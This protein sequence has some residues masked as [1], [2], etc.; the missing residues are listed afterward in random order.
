MWFPY[1]LKIFPWQRSNHLLKSEMEYYDMCVHANVSFLRAIQID[2]LSEIGTISSIDGNLNGNSA[3]SPSADDFEVDRND[4][5]FSEHSESEAADRSE[6]S[7]SE[8]SD[9]TQNIYRSNYEYAV[10]F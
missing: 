2:S 5:L 10:I 1:R 8:Q 4:E 7:I 6:I 9:T 3:S